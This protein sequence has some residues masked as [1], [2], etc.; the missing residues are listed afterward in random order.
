[1]KALRQF[2]GTRFAGLRDQ[3]EEL[4]M[5]VVE[6]QALSES[7]SDAEADEVDSSVRPLVRAFAIL[8][9]VNLVEAF[10]SRAHVIPFR[11]ENCHARDSRRGDVRGFHW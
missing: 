7:M 9:S 11:I 6:G 5:G 4:M 10:N 1:M 2:E 8:D 3:P